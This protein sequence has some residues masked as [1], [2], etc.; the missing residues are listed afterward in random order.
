L[1]HLQ[2]CAADYRALDRV[3]LPEEDLAASGAR[4]E[5]LSAAASSP[6]L[7]RA[8]DRLLDGT[9]TL[10]ARA[11][12]LPPA[13]KS[14]GLSRESAVIVE[15]AARLARR[16]RRGDPLATRVKLTRGDFAAALLVGLWRGGRP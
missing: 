13:V 15:L 11:R 6:G 14:P 2:D 3:Y 5:E 10:I 1:N 8:L 7:R 4:L 9:E 16:L 12:R